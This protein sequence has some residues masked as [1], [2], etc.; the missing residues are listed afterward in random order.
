MDHDRT[1]ES[2]MVLCTST[3]EQQMTI[4]SHSN[5]KV[6][7][8]E[9]RINSQYPKKVLIC[10]EPYNIIQLTIKSDNDCWLT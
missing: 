9:S 10:A 3:L 4:G 2:W 1:Y 6:P 8:I 5:V 7:Q